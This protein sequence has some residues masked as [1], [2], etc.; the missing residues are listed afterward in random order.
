MIDSIPLCPKCN[1]RRIAGGY[2]T[3]RPCLPLE[4]IVA[5]GVRLDGDD[6]GERLA[7]VRR[8]IAQYESGAPIQFEPR[9]DEVG[10]DARL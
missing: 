2:K 8:Y 1:V 10:T 4:S 5:Q 6:F 3:C 9:T 7:R